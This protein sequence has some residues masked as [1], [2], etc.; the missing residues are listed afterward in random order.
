MERFGINL[1]LLI[2]QL[3]NF[4]ICFGWLALSIY[5]LFAVRRQ[6][7]SP[8]T[9]ALWVLIVLAAPLIGA[10]AFWI[11]KPAGEITLM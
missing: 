5:T 8:T 9:Q 6:K 4:V 11:A 1:G 2:V 3:V 7:L 10:I